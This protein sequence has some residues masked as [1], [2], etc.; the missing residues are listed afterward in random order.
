[1]MELAAHQGAAQAFFQSGG[2][3]TFSAGG[4]ALDAQKHIVTSDG[5]EVELTY[6]EFELLKMLMENKGNVLS[7]TF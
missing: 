2:Q 7:G 5:T 1:M 4:V 6:K 3:E